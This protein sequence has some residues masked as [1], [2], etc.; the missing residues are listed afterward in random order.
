M[1]QFEKALNTNGKCFQYLI[2]AFPKL[3]CDKIKADVFDGPQIRLVRDKKFAEVMI[4]REK[5]T[6]LSFVAVMQNFLKNIK[7]ENYQ[8]L[9]ATMLLTFQDL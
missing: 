8:V 5:V 7:A 3:F 6:W 2:H 9:V 4:N 1:K